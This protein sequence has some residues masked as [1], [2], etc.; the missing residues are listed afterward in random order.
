MES[1]QLCIDGVRGCGVVVMNGLDESTT[2]VR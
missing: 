2:R 1:R